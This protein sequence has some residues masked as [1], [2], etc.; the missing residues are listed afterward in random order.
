MLGYRGVLSRT[1]AQYSLCQIVRGNEEKWFASLIRPTPQFSKPPA[2][3]QSLNRL[4]LGIRLACYYKPHTE[5]PVAEELL[6]RPGLGFCE[7]F[8]VYWTLSILYSQCTERNQTI[9]LDRICEG[10]VC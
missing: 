2:N 4:G 8:E 10:R 7:V 1:I 6:P 9:P 5:N 3:W